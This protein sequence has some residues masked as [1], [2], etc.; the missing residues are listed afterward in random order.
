MVWP[1]KKSAG[2]LAIAFCVVTLNKFLAGAWQLRV[3]RLQYHGDKRHQ[4][5]LI[6]KCKIVASILNWF[7]TLALGTRGVQS[8]ALAVMFSTLYK[9]ESTFLLLVLLGE[10]DLGLIILIR[11]VEE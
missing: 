6:R 8:W 5:V 4:S 11:L 9:I 7:R 3:K 10:F 2:Q 1:N